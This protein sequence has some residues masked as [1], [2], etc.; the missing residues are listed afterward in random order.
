VA[1]TPIAERFV[2]EAGATL[3]VSRVGD[4]ALPLDEVFAGVEYQR[5]R[6]RHD[7]GL[8]EW[9]GPTSHSERVAPKLV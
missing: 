2:R 5:M 6:L 4:D 7:Q 3:A 9:A 8:E 1:N